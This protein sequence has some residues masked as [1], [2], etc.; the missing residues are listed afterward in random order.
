[1]ELYLKET[2]QALP[3]GSDRPSKSANFSPYGSYTVTHTLCSVVILLTAVTAIVCPLSEEHAQPK[4]FSI[5]RANISIEQLA[6]FRHLNICI[7]GTSRQAKCISV[8][9]PNSVFNNVDIFEPSLR[10]SHSPKHISSLLSCV[11]LNPLPPSNTQSY[12]F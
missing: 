2:V 10:Y 6:P 5:G 1:M 4:R 12:C 8:P 7:Y 9:S 3:S 11:S